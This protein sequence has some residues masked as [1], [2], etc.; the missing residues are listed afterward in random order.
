MKKVTIKLTHNGADTFEEFYRAKLDT[1]T[2]DNLTTLVTEIKGMIDGGDIW[3]RHFDTDGEVNNLVYI[4]DS[5]NALTAF[6]TAKN[7]IEADDDHIETIIEDITFDDFASYAADN[8]ETEIAH[9]RKDNIF[10]NL[11]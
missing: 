7:L 8:D 10:N 3:F 4:L 1:M 2:D 11:S 6:Q 5:N 9:E